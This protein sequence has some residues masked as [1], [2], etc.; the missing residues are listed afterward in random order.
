MLLP[1]SS[2]SFTAHV[3]RLVSGPPDVVVSLLRSVEDELRARVEWAFREHV[4][5]DLPGAQVGDLDA[6]VGANVDTEAGA[7]EARR[8]DTCCEPETVLMCV[9]GNC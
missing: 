9:L 6:G 3:K 5:G 2:T 1:P 7:V 4:L 8:V